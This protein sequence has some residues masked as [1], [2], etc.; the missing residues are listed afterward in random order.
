MSATEVHT[1]FEHDD[2]LANV[3]ACVCCRRVSAWGMQALGH[4]QQRAQPP[5]PAAGVSPAAQ[6]LLALAVAG[7]IAWQMQQTVQTVTFGIAPA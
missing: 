2:L 7:D 1:Q 6:E 3:L 4:I 5:G